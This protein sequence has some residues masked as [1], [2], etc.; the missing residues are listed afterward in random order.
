[1]EIV[2]NGKS[3][4]IAQPLTVAGLLRANDVPPQF[5][6]V[7]INGELLDKDAYERALCDGDRL[8]VVRFVGGG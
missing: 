4:D 1:M 8:E 3:Q 6:A 5:T 2:L 7:E